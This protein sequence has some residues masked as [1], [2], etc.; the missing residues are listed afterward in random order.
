MS[1][2]VAIRSAALSDAKRLLE[3]YAYYVRETAVSFE[4]D[5]PS[6]SEFET[7]MRNTLKNY[8][9][10]VIEVNGRIAGYAYAG[11][12]VG[13]QAYDR[14]CELS[15]Y[16]D[17]T[18]CK[19]GLG[20]RL[21]EAMES[22]L[23]KRGFLNLYASIA[24]PESEDEFLTRNSADFHAHMGF[25]EV[26][27]FHKCGHKFGRWYDMIWMEK[28]IGDHTGDCIENQTKFDL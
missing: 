27:R 25:S 19:H 10:L 1:E 7:R 6:L 28:I 21:Y 17:R 22:E 24:Y 8:P 26:G 15:I 3:I 12:F 20:R 14:S 4:Y 18:A 9:Y 13:R 16:L 2:S 5:V 23:K 11:P